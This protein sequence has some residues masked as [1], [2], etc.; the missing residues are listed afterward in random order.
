MHEAIDEIDGLERPAD[1]DI[2]LLDLDLLGQ[3]LIPYLLA[4]GP[5]VRPEAVDALEH[6]DAQCV[7]VDGYSVV[8]PAHDFGGHVAGGT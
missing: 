3:Y 2:L 6:D 8:A 4:V 7:V 5:G 1:G